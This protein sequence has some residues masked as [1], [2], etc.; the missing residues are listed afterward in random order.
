M[1]QRRLLSLPVLAALLLSCAPKRAEVTLSTEATPAPLLLKLVAE[2]SAL[3]STLVGG[4]IVSFESPELDGS[5]SFESNLKKPDSLLVKFEG[6]FGIDVGTF[7]LCK[8]QYIMYNSFENTVTVGNP[9]SAAIRSLIPFELTPEQILNA[10]AGVF[11]IAQPETE[12]KG[13][14]IDDDLF[15]L[16]Y[17]CGSNTCEYWVDARYLLV[18]R[19]EQHDANNTLLVEARAYAFVEQETAAAARRVQITFPQQG[20]RLSIAYNS[21]KLNTP[22]TDFRFSIPA[23]AKKNFRP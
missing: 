17:A 6:P 13:Y 19:F 15:R 23:N 4:G 2:R 7:F 12:L 21:M 14:T 18:T 16:T 20:R 3:I 22:E 5:A 1:M 8:N 11:V 10:F 9:H